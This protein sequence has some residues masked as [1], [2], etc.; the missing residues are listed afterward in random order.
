MFDAEAFTPQAGSKEEKMHTKL[1]RLRVVW[2]TQAC[3]GPHKNE[4]KPMLVL[5]ASDL[6]CVGVLKKLSLSSQD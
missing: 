4:L 1:G 2:N 3:A 6:A 5:C